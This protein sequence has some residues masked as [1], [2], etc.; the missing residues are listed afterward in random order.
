MQNSQKNRSARIVLAPA[1]LAQPPFDVN[2][3]AD[4]LAPRLEGF[5]GDFILAR[6]SGGQSNPTYRLEGPGAS[7]VLRT[8]PGPASQLLPSAHAVEREFRIQAALR[9]TDVPVARV[10]HLCADEAVIGRAFYVMEHVVGRVFWEPALP[11]LPPAERA[12][13]FDEMNRVIA[14]LHAVDPAAVG[15]ADYGKPGNYFARQI[16]RWSRQYQASRTEDVPAMDAL[17]EWLPAHI[18]VENPEPV[19]LVHGDF[20][21]DNLIFHAHEPRV[22]AILDWE[23]ST[24]GH[25]LADFAYHCMV[26]HVLPEVFRGIAGLDFDALG[27]PQ[28][29]EYVARYLRRTGRTIHGDWNFYLAYNMFRMASILQGIRK[30]IDE[31]TAASAE[32]MQA[33]AAARPLAELAWL[34]ARKVAA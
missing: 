27:I 24:L 7:F 20:R 3:L 5:E 6:F 23:L 8:K 22:I 9:D 33:G 10:F 13:L 14:A 26:W 11:G 32:A 28:P 2:R 31:G 12:A 4:Y 17:I 30:R 16:S 29:D 21:L 15:L 25:P 1:E 18:P 34:Y 19:T